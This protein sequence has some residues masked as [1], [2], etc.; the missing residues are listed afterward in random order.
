ML[1]YQKHTKHTKK[2]HVVRAEPPFTVK[3]MDCMQQTEPTKG[4]QHP[5]VCY[6]HAWC[7]LSLP[8]CRSLCQKWESLADSIAGISYYLNEC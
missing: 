3:T 4:A 7:L 5:A 2:Y 1:I 8:L 6:C